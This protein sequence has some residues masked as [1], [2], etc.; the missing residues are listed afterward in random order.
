MHS[1]SPVPSNIVHAGL[2]EGVHLV[3]RVAIGAFT[4]FDTMS[5]GRARRSRPDAIVD[6]P[7]IRKRRRFDTAPSAH[8]HTK[9]E[10][11]HLQLSVCDTHFALGMHSARAYLGAAARGGNA[12]HQINAGNDID[13]ARAEFDILEDRGGKKH[14]ESGDEEP[15]HMPSVMG[16]AF[17]S[18]CSSMSSKIVRNNVRI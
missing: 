13:A 1:I 9:G 8:M 6:R 4:G 10:S 12:T 11:V 14:D 2:V 7:R 18:Q 15:A 3:R 5:P 16:M 17:S